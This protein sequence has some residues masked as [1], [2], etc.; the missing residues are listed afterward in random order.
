MLAIYWLAWNY[1]GCVYHI[2]YK[3]LNVTPLFQHETKDFQTIH[4]QVNLEYK[5]CPVAHV[6]SILS[7]PNMH[8]QSFA[9]AV[10]IVLFDLLEEPE[11][12]ELLW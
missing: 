5:V 4:Q 9:E 1:L 3:Q 6:I 8:Q 10:M 11:W 12:F 2:V 7:L